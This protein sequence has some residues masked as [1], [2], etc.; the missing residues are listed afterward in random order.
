MKTLQLVI[1]GTV[2]GVGYR[3]S[4]RR[5][6]RRLAVAGWVR[7]RDDG[8]VEAV[9]HGPEEAVEALLRWAHRGP[10]LARVDRVEVQAVEGSHTEF[11]IRP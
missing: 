6:A 9:V 3:D 5:E 2:Q 11:T 8:A 7:N 4:M 10:A 1:Q